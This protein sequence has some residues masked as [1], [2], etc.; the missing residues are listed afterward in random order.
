MNEGNLLIKHNDKISDKYG[1]NPY[2]RTI[3]Q[4]LEK[5]V[6]VIDKDAG[7][8]SHQS[9]DFLKKIL[10][11]PKAG[12]SGTLDPKVTGILVCGLGKGT[13]LMEYMLKSN[14]EYPQ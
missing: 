6:I 8:T 9:A 5:G 3:E 4:L 13:R 7:P 10:K 1:I 2:E 12:H 11:I 14:K